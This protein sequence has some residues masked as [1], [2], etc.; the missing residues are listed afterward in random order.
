[1]GTLSRVFLQAI[2]RGT[3]V[4]ARAPV[5]VCAVCIIV[6]TIQ[7]VLHHL[8]LSCVSHAASEGVHYL[9]NVTVCD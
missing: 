9:S 1:M 3:V 6:I 4:C 8:Y 5:R 2:R 7:E